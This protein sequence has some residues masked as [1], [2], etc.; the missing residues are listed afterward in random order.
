MYYIKLIAL[1]AVSQYLFFGAMTGKARKASGLIASAIGGSAEFERMYRVQMNTLEMI[2][3]LL[4][5]LFLAG[6]HQNPVWVAV[7]G[8][9]YLYQFRHFLAD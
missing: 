5:A 9:V 6:Q 8:S 2:I 7:I 3:A 1:L 4:P